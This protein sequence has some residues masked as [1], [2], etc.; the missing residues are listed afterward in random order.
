VESGAHVTIRQGKNVR[1]LDVP[2]AVYCNDAVS[3]QGTAAIVG[4]Q[5]QLRY[6]DVA[7]GRVD[8]LPW[9][10]CCQKIAFVDETLFVVHTRGGWHELNAYGLGQSGLDLGPKVKAAAILGAERFLVFETDTKGSFTCVQSIDG[11][12]SME[13]FLGRYLIFTKDGEGK[14][15][16]ES[17]PRTWIFVE[18]E[19][20][21][22]FLAAL[23]KDAGTLVERDGRILGSRGF[24]L[25]NL[26]AAAA[27]V[28]PRAATHLPADC[29]ARPGERREVAP[30]R[31]RLEMRLVAGPAA[32]PPS[33]ST[34][35]P[36]RG[37]AKARDGVKD[38]L[39]EPSTKGTKLSLSA[40]SSRRATLAFVD[41]GKKAE[42]PIHP[43]LSGPIIEYDF[44]V[45]GSRCLVMSRK[46]WTLSVWEVDVGSGV[47]EAIETGGRV[48]TKCA[49]LGDRVVLA[50]DGGALAETI[51][52]FTRKAG[53]Y[54][55]ETTLTAWCDT[56]FRVSCGRRLVAGFEPTRRYLGV[57]SAVLELVAGVPAIVGTLEQGVHR[58]WE[59][60][61]ETLVEAIDGR[62]YEIALA[63][64]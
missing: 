52:C 6:I 15:E 18:K 7:T 51:D 21:L 27:R 25:V 47:A 61:G 48:Y 60:G 31:P 43:A 16:R 5:W 26:D 4:S 58:A 41:R 35:S 64:T 28:E 49:Y 30:S 8:E 39:S 37:Y 44:H 12:A 38:W 17:D 2:L 56:L 42:R 45:D 23:A 34:S 54:V 33:S 19:R 24:E 46:D 63:A 1:E 53:A 9:V 50:G 62:V 32:R 40:K 11:D 36:C 57:G 59:D 14:P 20:K 29:G 13:G 55:K 22:V 3:P 10:G